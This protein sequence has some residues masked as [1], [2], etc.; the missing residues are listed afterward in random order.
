MGKKERQR[1]EKEERKN[2]ESVCVCACV[3]GCAHECV[4]VNGREG[5]RKRGSE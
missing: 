2:R 3:R 4:W 1:G 5:E